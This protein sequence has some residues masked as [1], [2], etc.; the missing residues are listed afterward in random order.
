MGVTA[1]SDINELMKHADTKG[2]DV[3][4]IPYGGSVVPQLKEEYD[5]LIRELSTT[6]E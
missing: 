4:V 5:R 1:F 3:Y 6:E 2:K